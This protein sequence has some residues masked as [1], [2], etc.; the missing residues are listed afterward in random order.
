MA[1]GVL[2]GGCGVHDPE[3]E[4]RI[5]LVA[6]GVELR[7]GGLD[8]D[9]AVALA[10]PQHFGRRALRI[11]VGELH[12]VAA[13]MRGDGQI[14]RHR[15]L[16]RSAL[17]GDHCDVLHLEAPGLGDVRGMLGRVPESGEPDR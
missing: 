11:G 7:P 5:G 15:R 8:D 2:G 10:R 6:G 17:A 1:D 9:R 12:G 13:P 3:V 14:D 4:G 16:A